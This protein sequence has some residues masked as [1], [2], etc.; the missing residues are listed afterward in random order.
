MNYQKIWTKN[1]SIYYDYVRV[2]GW[3]TGNL[4]IDTKIVFWPNPRVE[5]RA[6][7]VESVCSKPCPK[8]QV[9]VCL[10]IS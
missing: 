10:H 6:P 2:G 5:M 7:V 8:G 4:T 3:D 9:K 1:G